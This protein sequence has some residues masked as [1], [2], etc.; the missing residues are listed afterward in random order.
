[1]GDEDAALERIVGAST[2][3][4]RDGRK[5][6]VLRCHGGGAGIEQ[7]E[8]T[9]AI[10]ILG[11]PGLEAGLTEKRGLLIAGDTRDGN[12]DAMDRRVGAN[13]GRGDDARQHGAWNVEQRE[14]L[15]V[16]IAAVNVE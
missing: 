1:A 8:A 16:P 6:M 2:A 5:E 15:I 10:G 9:R 12:G 14:Q 4:P 13:A 7:K 3:P 11:K